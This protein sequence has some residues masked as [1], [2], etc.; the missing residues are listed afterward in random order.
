VA[1]SEFGRS[2]LRRWV[3]YEQWPK[4]Q[5]IRCGLDPMF[6]NAKSVP[7]P[8]ARRLVCVGRLAEQKGHLTLIE[9]A[10]RLRSE[11]VDFELIV[12]GDGPLRGEVQR[13]I[14]NHDLQEQVRLVGWQS[15]A[16]VRDLIQSCRAMVLP[17]FA[18]GLPVVIMEALALGRP[19][20]STYVAGIPELV[21]PGVTGWLVPASSVESLCLA[22]REVLDAPGELLERMGRA[23]AARVAEQHN[24]AIEAGKLVHLIRHEA[25]GG[26]S[27]V[28]HRTLQTR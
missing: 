5:V 17:S 14:A 25:K 21:R 18:E 26:A 6:L 22:T 19:V 27:A 4:I 15:N 3:P 13:L 8:T 20:I 9:A 7:L 28:S 1:I 10:A 24:A 23:G 12:A 16:R 11:G 2:Q